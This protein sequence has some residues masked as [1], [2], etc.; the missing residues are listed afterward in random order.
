M[1][2][3]GR[4][5]VGLDAPLNRLIEP[6]NANGIGIREGRKVS[7]PGRGGSEAAARGEG[8][9]KAVQKNAD[10]WGLKQCRIPLDA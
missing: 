7:P 10:I 8:R 9:F 1:E 2:L 4:P 5:T 3:A 6:D